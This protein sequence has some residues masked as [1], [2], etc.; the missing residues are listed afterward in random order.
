M[1]EGRFAARFGVRGRTAGL[2][3]QPGRVDRHV[4]GL[5]LPGRGTR[6]V[7]ATWPLATLHLYTTG[8]RFSSTFGW[9]SVIPTWEALYTEIVDVQAVGKFPLLTTGIRIT[10]RPNREWVIFWSLHRPN[11]LRDLAGRGL[12]VH[13]DPVRFRF[14]D[15]G[16]E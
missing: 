5:K 3:T 15:P 10:I 16:R 7:D 2:G 11:V 9:L 8:L 14:F 1:T 12:E 4:G 6:G 13:A